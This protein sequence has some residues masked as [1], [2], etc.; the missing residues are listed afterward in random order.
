MTALGAREPYC[1][2]GDGVEHRLYV[3]RRAGDDAEYFTRCSLLLQRFLEFFEQPDVLDGDDR[4]VGKGFDE[5]D[6]R[7]GEG[8]HL[9]ATCEQSANEFPLLTKG[10]GQ[11]GAKVAERN[12]SLGIRSARGH[13]E[14]GARRARASSETVAHQY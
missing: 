1:A 11:D 8:A 10:N 5:F 12:P 14:C 6:L 7:R 3:R 9:G 13:R 4:L 2:L